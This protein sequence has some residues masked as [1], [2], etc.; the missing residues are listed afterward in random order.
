MEKQDILEA[1]MDNVRKIIDE[2]NA[3]DA[4]TRD[5]KQ[6]WDKL[7]KSGALEKVQ[8]KN[9]IIFDRRTREIVDKKH[10][11]FLRNYL[12]HEEDLFYVIN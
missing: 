8:V 12:G 2:K 9:G 10:R 5:H 4:R 11:T 7:V 3:R 6:A 1:R